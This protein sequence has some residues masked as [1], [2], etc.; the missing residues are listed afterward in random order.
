MFG[1]RR[2]PDRRGRTSTEAPTE[3][4]CPLTPCLPDAPGDHRS[5]QPESDSREPPH[6]PQSVD[7]KSERYRRGPRPRDRTL[8]RRVRPSLRVSGRVGGRRPPP[9]PPSSPVRCNVSGHPSP[10]LLS[11]EPPTGLGDCHPRAPLRQFDRRPLDSGPE[12]GAYRSR[13]PSRS[14]GYRRTGGPTPPVDPIRL[15]RPLS[16][17]GVDSGPSSPERFWRRRGLGRGRTGLTLY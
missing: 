3:V 4:P 17:F 16:T 8:R 1:R 5:S 7:P 14:N 9:T 11:P 12:N 15:P 6:P 2:T 10:S 13:G